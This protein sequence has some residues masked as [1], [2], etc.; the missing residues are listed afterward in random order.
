[1]R[2]PFRRLRCDDGFAALAAVLASACFALLAAQAARTSR[3][4]IVD[5]NAA[6]VHARLEAAG[7]AGLAIAMDHMLADDPSARWDIDGQT[8]ETPFGDADL[9]ITVEDERG[10]LPLN[11]ITEGQARAMFQLAGA[12]A[13]TADQLTAAFMDWRNPEKLRPA[14]TYATP[15]GDAKE[16]VSGFRTVQELQLLPGMT[17]ALYEALTPFV[18]VDAGATAFDARTASPFATQVM[19]GGGPAGV[20]AIEKRREAACQRTA[21]EATP[22]VSLAGRVLTIRVLAA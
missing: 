11:R 4:G 15:V 20:A 16:G 22:S 10:K 3:S 7:G 17:P 13:A 12:D 14:P 1:M 18:S 8:Y 6:A 19:A 21:F 5:A 2:P 9:R